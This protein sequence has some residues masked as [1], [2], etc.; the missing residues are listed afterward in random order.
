[1]IDID[2]KEKADWFR[3][4]KKTSYSWYLDIVQQFKDIIEGNDTE[5]IRETYYADKDI[6]FFI[7]VLKDLG[8]WET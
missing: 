2:V 6:E 5:N 8:E 1:M 4:I 3:S 7:D